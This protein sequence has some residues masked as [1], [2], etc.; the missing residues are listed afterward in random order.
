MPVEPASAL[1]QRLLDPVGVGLGFIPDV[2]ELLPPHILALVAGRV[3]PGPPDL[4]LRHVGGRGDR[5]LLLTAGPKVLRGD[6]DDAVCVDVEGHLN[7]GHARRR[8]ADAVQPEGPEP[9]VVPDKSPLP[10]I[11]VDVHRRLE[12]RRGCEY[13]AVPGRYCRVPLDQPRGDAAD[14]LDRERERRDV[15]EHHRGSLGARRKCPAELSALDCCPHRDALVR[16]DVAARLLAEHGSHLVDD[17]RHTGRTPDQQDPVYIGGGQARVHEGRADRHLGPL[18]EVPGQVV[19][20]FAGDR[21]FHVERTV[22]ADRNERQV[23]R[24][25]GGCGEGFFAFFSLFENPGHRGAVLP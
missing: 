19:E 20:I 21:H 18:H 12:R 23:H 24:V 3:L 4:L 7:L 16:V 8:P 13:L 2:N 22:P 17:D 11:D 15:E 9:L 25:G 6:L 10:L 5:D 1:L 14:R